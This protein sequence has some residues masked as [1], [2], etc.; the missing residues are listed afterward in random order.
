MTN[1]SDSLMTWPGGERTEG[2]RGKLLWGT[3]NS[4]HGF[5]WENKSWELSLKPERIRLHFMV[6]DFE[7]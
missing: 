2:E 4:Y 5:P 7:T 6:K 1:D 3:E